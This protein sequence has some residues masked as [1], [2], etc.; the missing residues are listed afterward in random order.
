MM[1]FRL[2]ID[3][4]LETGAFIWKISDLCVI[5]ILSN[6]VPVSFAQCFHHTTLELDSVPAVYWYT[7]GG[8]MLGGRPYILV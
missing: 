8:I 6:I 7:T 3:L 5:R 2:V 1:N 4:P